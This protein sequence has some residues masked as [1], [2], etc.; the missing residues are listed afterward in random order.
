M[1]NTSVSVRVCPPVMCSSMSPIPTAYTVDQHRLMGQWGM[2][3][4]T[5][6]SDASGEM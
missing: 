4:R 2:A 1:Y 3:F 6:K 5:L